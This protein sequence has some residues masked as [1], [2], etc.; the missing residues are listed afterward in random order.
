MDAELLGDH[1]YETKNLT[2]FQRF[3]RSGSWLLGACLSATYAFAAFLGGHVT[4]EHWVIAGAASALLS[5]FTWKKWSERI[6]TELAT[7]SIPP[8]QGKRLIGYLGCGFSLVFGVALIIF[9]DAESSIPI[10][11]MF[12][13]LAISWAVAFLVPKEELT[14]VAQKEKAR[15]ESAV[16]ESSRESNKN[17]DEGV[18]VIFGWLA[19][20]AAI[21]AVIALFVYAPWWAAV[22]IVLLVLVLFK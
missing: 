7:V 11:L 20:I 8:S 4:S 3:R 2:L 10:G 15:L 13:L 5:W 22:I 17:F 1:A 19:V 21:G 6:V 12:L 9:G 18:S 14:T 16:Y